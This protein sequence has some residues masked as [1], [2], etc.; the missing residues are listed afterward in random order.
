MSEVLSC[1]YVNEVSH[2]FFFH[3]F[4][5]HKKWSKSCWSQGLNRELPAKMERNRIGRTWMKPRISAAKME[6]S[7]KMSVCTNA[8][9]WM[10]CDKFQL[11]Q[12]SFSSIAYSQVC[13]SV[14]RSEPKKSYGQTQT[15]RNTDP[16]GGNTFN[17]KELNV[18]ATRANMPYY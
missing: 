13:P 6:I 4:K 9:Q 3:F 7:T 14:R 5:K 1:P 2:F 17:G 12:F 11:F 8:R 15:N 10:D 16:T 18:T